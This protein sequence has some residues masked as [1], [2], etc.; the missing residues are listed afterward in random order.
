[1]S[2]PA[3]TP[4]RL[5]IPTIDTSAPRRVKD[6]PYNYS[7]WETPLS[8]Q[9][10]RRP[11]L[12]Y[13]MLSEPSPTSVPSTPGYSSSHGSFSSLYMPNGI[14]APIRAVNYVES[15]A[16]PARA[17]QDLS[18]DMMMGEDRYQPAMI[19]A[20]QPKYQTHMVV[21][22]V[23]HHLTSSF[24]SNMSGAWDSMA[25]AQL[26][27]QPF[28]FRPSTIQRVDSFTNTD[29]MPRSYAST[30]TPHVQSVVPTCPSATTLD[31]LQMQGFL[32]PHHL[33][34][35]NDIPDH[36]TY[37]YLQSV[38]SSMTSP[39]DHAPL[40]S[41]SFDSLSS[42][43]PWSPHEAP[44]PISEYVL[45]G[46]EAIVGNGIG[47]KDELAMST[48][49]PISDWDEHSPTT[50]RRSRLRGKS[51]SSKR[52]RTMTHQLAHNYY[53]VDVAIDSKSLK[54]DGNGRITKKNTGVETKRWKCHH[55]GCESRS[56]RKEHLR[57][58][59]LS[60]NPEKQFH[61]NLPKC[62]RAITRSDNLIQHLMTHV[63]PPKPGKRNNHHSPKRVER[64][65]MQTMKDQKLAERTITNLR[66]AIEREQDKW[67]HGMDDN[68]DDDMDWN[69]SDSKAGASDEENI[70]R[71]K[72]EN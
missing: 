64:M 6:D 2:T 61:C 71:L 51:T 19:N 45:P 14:S 28:I 65:V 9:S 11:S 59:E 22:P 13:S 27:S 57:R 43:S 48:M 33:V 10:C 42:M 37:D 49:L 31:S 36:D 52:C 72:Y 50:P 1:M 24:S 5:Y 25:P 70:E 38:D 44:S 15:E 23:D 30:M 60:H 54:V 17:M 47:L 40:G 63:R 12:T 68:E 69:A 39:A 55:E 41:A 4:Q 32:S 7:G 53:G 21:S 62:N 26:S 35:S 56:A 18:Y 46:T 67:P 3:R 20:V 66:K 16:E 58:H 34:N 29:S 8:A